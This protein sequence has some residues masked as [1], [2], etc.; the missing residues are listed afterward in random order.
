MSTKN[1]A[2]KNTSETASQS[3]AMSK[4]IAKVDEADS[5]SQKRMYTLNIIIIIGILIGI[6]VYMHNVDGFDNILHVLQSADY[7]WMIAGLVCLILMWLC[8]TITFHFPFKKIYR[9]QTFFDSFRANM[10]GQL[11]NNLTPFASG[12]Q[13][14]EAYVLKKEGRRASDAFSVLTM[15][16]VITQT[17]LILFTLVVV[18]TQFKFFIN[19]F[20][21]LVW[22][23]IIGII[24]NIGIV[25]LFFLMGINKDLVIKMIKPLVV[26][27][28]KIHIGKFRL[29]KDPDEKMAKFI[30]SA[31]N[32]SLQFSKIRK[33][34]GLLVIMTVFG[35]I[36]NILYYA[37]TYMVYRAFGNVG[38]T[39]FQIVTTQAFLMLIMTIFPTPGAGIGAEGGFLLLFSSIF[40][41]ETLSLSI[42]FWRIYVFY[43][44]IIV[45]ALFFIPAKRKENIE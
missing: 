41:K 34:N 33:Q 13:L 36:Q 30:D 43:L 20:K 45:G 28:G 37:I 35:L 23:G 21:N 9:D 7:K 31:N 38:A 15:K 3:L 12:G 42:L 24:I 22:I 44:P 39:F 6:F 29:I 32:F 25:V 26:F 4:K 17:T 40:K 14:M 19:L 1:K 16:F 8:E 2:K 11:F 27:A 5:K 18:F 10:I